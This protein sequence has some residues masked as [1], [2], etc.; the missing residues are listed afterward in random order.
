M[1]ELIFWPMHATFWSVWGPQTDAVLGVRCTDNPRDCRL[2]VAVDG[3]WM[4]LREWLH[5]SSNIPQLFIK[6]VVG[7]GRFVIVWTADCPLQAQI[8]TF[9]CA[10]KYC[11]NIIITSPTITV[12]TTGTSD[13]IANYASRV[14]EML[15]VFLT[16]S[17]LV[18]L[19]LRILANIITSAAL[20]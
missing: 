10:Q 18:V 16:P 1:F 11:Q 4:D 2:R 9:T 7:V 14:M 3:W 5:F 15:I 12:P 20:T 17:P 8:S 13:I 6:T 19:S